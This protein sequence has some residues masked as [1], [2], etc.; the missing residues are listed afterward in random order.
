VEA[1]LNALAPAPAARARSPVEITAA[2]ALLACAALPFWAGRYLPFLDLPQHLALSRIIADYHDPATHF[3]DYYAIDWRITPYW[4]F[5]AAMEVL[6]LAVPVELAARLLFTAYAVGLPLSAAY[7]LA[8][9]GRDWRWAVLTFPLVYNTNLFLGFATFNLSLPLFLFALGASERHLASDRFDL[10]DAIS[11]AALAALVYLFHVQ[12]YAL[13][14]LCVVTLGALHWRGLR[15]AIVCASPYAF[16]LLLFA[17]WFWRSFVSPEAQPPSECDVGGHHHQSYGRLGDLDPQFE[18]VPRLV[19]TIPERLVGAFNDGSDYRIAAALLVVFLGALALRGP[20]R[21]NVTGTL[22]EVV[23][24]RRG[25][26]VCLVLFCGYVFA[27]I[28]IKGQ[29]YINPRHLVFAALTAPLLLGAPAS[30]RG[31]LLLVAGVALAFTA[32]ANAARQ[33]SRFQE[34]VG[35][36]DAVI[37]RTQPGRRMMGLI[38]EDGDGGAIR[39]WPFV[40]W[41]CY[42]QVRRGGDV[43]FS[44]AGLPSIPVVYRRGMRGPHPDEWSPEDFDWNTMAP[45]YDWFLVR[46]RPV[47]GATALLARAD[48]VAAAGPWTLY[49][50]RMARVTSS[51]LCSPPR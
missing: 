37:S 30:G 29:W 16:S 28:E 5:Y 15:W 19:A 33:I 18:S 3:G 13:L 42:Y 10:R 31:R 49:R 40:H 2:A 36:F 34:E 22:R 38:F 45:A 44:F 27:P 21:S 14:G 46:G 8:S 43:S 12:S 6:Q 4:G 23:L 32:S 39:W 35:P 25:Q 48:L 24:E 17:P 26:V 50:Q 51:G 20:R 11:V 47:G 9:F 41:T 7:C 1:S